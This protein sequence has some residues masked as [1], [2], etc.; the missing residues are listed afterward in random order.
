MIISLFLDSTIINLITL[1]K[2]TPDSNACNLWLRQL[3]E[4]GVRIVLPE[5]TYYERWRNLLLEMRREQKRHRGLQTT[6]IRQ[7]QTLRELRN[8]SFITYVKLTAPTIDLAA[9]LW[10]EVRDNG[11][12]TAQPAALDVDAILCAQARIFASPR[13]QV[14]IATENEKHLRLFDVDV[15]NW[16]GDWSDIANQV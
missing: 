1:P 13:K 2:A 5:I 7:E 16:R 14:I 4:L 15:R 8:S 3:I 10:A 9:S 6:W 11:F 12:A